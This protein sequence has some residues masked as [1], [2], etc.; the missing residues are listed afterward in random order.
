MEKELK[1]LQEA[2]DNLGEKLF[3]LRKAQS[4][5]KNQF[6]SDIV[7][8]LKSITMVAEDMEYRLPGVR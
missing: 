5:T 1:E 3:L 8:P 7:V 4:L 6:H 2:I